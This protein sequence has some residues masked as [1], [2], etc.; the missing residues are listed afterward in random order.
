MLRVKVRAQKSVA[1]RREAAI[2]LLVALPL[3][4]ASFKY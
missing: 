2:T 1:E 3:F 4:D